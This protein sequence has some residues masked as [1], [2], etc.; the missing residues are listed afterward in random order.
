MSETVRDQLIRQG[1]ITP[2]ETHEARRAA[3]DAARPPEPE[4]E[5]PPP[6]EAPPRGVVVES[7]KAGHGRG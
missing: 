7:G 3:A 4:K 5:L 2:A 6:F 1:I